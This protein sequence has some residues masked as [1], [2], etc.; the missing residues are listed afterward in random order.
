MLFLLHKCKH[1]H[2]NEY[3]HQNRSQ[4]HM[5]FSLEVQLHR[6]LSLPSP[7]LDAHSHILLLCRCKQQLL[8]CPHQQ[9]SNLRGACV[10]LKLRVYHSHVFSLFS[11][12][13][14]E[15]VSNVELIIQLDTA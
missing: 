9:S 10:G 13:K 6:L 15:H 12:L 14:D 5:H 1:Q 7:G 11:P 3:E 2:Q 4:T 8:A